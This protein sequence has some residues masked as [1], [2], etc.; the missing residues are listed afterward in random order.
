MGLRLV[1]LMD[2]VDS[3][4]DSCGS[5]GFRGFADCIVASSVAEEE[6][7]CTNCG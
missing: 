3:F 4:M 7:L 6:I 5:N 1:D 2:L